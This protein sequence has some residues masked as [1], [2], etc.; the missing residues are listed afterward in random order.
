MGNYLTATGKQVGLLLNFGEKK[1]KVKQI[2]PC[3][4]QA[5]CQKKVLI[6]QQNYREDCG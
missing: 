4:W 2:Y 3:L 1:V 5:G 6:N